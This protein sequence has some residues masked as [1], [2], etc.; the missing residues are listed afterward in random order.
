M[1]PPANSRDNVAD[2]FAKRNLVNS[3]VWTAAGGFFAQST[4]SSTVRQETTDSSY[5]LSSS[6]EVGIGLELS[7]LGVSAGFEL[8][9]SSGG[10]RN[11]TKTA[12]K[13][14]ETSYEI[15]VSVE[16]SGNVETAGKVDAYR[17]LTFS[18]EPS[19]ENFD[20]LFKTVV[21]PIWLA[22]S[23]H[24]NAVAL[25]QANN[26]EKKPPCW[27]V[28]HRVTFVSR[29]LPA[30]PDST[31][32]PLDQALMAANVQSNWQLIQRLDPLVRN[33]TSDFK[34]FADAVRKAI[35]RYLPELQLHETDIA[36]YMALYYG[37]NV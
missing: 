37:L 20:T 28:F 18:Q 13:D 15:E 16:T 36:E 8:N 31:M 21:D 35:R 25:R 9:A 11:V 22:Q 14:S 6:S 27:R 33:Q 24:P 19:P 34:V 10:Q 17:F 30:F 5:S 29:I 23:N 12:T 26:S 7:G 3:Y 32:T 4:Q 1:M 2:K